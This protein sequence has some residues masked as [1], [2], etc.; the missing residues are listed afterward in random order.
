MKLT[1]QEIYFISQALANVQIKGTDAMFVAGVMT[2]VQKELETVAQQ[3]GLELPGANNLPPATGPG[4]G[5]VPPPSEIAEPPAD[6]A[7]KT[8]NKKS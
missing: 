1:A 5:V 7:T 2:K 6:T 8:A 3:E 4:A